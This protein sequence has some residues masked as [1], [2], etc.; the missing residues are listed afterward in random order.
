MIHWE[1][2]RNNL[3]TNFPPDYTIGIYS[4]M[5]IINARQR[6]SFFSDSIAYLSLI[7]QVKLPN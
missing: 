2:F 3:L 1:S 7:Y 4:S 5:R 6:A